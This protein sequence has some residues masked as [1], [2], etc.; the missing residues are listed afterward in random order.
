MKEDTKDSLDSGRGELK[1][2]GGEVPIPIFP[3]VKDCGIG[4]VLS[5]R[6]MDNVI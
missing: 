3:E 5:G 4:K 6:P 1:G 2:E